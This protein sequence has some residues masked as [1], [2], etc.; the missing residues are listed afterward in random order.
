MEKPMTTDVSEARQL[1][2]AAA[3][4]PHLFFAVNNTASWRAQA[5]AAATRAVT[6]RRGAFS[7]RS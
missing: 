4:K 7:F 1:A 6:K 5:H 2:A 3:A